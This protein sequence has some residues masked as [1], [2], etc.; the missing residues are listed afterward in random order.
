MRENFLFQILNNNQDEIKEI[1]TNEEGLA[2][3]ILPY[4]KYTIIQENTT[5][6]YQKVD[7]ISINVTNTEE[8]IIELK[9]LKIPVPNTHTEQNNY[10]GLLFLIIIILL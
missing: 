1:T 7:P 10:L 5:S 8:E 2:T 9:D 4:G 6:G 3:I